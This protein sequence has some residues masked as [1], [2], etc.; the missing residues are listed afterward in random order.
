ML[1]VMCM[2]G[3]CV[4]V[5]CYLLLVHT[6]VYI[7]TH[8]CTHMF[9]CIHLSFVELSPRLSLYSVFTIYIYI[10]IIYNL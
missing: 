1:F 9:V 5:E 2:S 7:H 3:A 10:S 4:H 8:A 6:H